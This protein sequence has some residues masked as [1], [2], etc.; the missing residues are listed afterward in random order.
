M[1]Y[2]Y[3]GTGIEYPKITLGGVEYELKVTRGALIYRFSQRGISLASLK[4]ETKRVSACIDALH[5]MMGSQ[6]AGTPEELTE[7]IFAEDKFKESLHAVMV[8]VGKVSPPKVEPAQAA[9]GAAPI[10]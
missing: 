2:E 5:A 6:F 7:M 9:A 10:Q 4:D 1:T 3:N 8:A